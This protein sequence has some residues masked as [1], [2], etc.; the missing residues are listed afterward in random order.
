[1][2]YT[3]RIRAITGLA[4]VFRRS[5]DSALHIDGALIKDLV[6]SESSY[7][8]GFRPV[9]PSLPYPNFPKCYRMFRRLHIPFTRPSV[10]DGII[11]FDRDPYRL[12]EGKFAILQLGCG[13]S[14]LVNELNVFLGLVLYRTSVHTTYQ[15]VGMFEVGMKNKGYQKRLNISYVTI[16]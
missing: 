4:D 8:S 3:P 1:M 14:R 5:R 12:L 15:R 6:L 9:S 11:Y 10:S 13:K 7:I 2:S 16:S